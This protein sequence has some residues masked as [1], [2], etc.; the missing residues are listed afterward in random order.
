MR[1]RTVQSCIPMKPIINSK[2]S[3]G[4][5]SSL[6]FMLAVAMAATTQAAVTITNSTTFD[7]GTGLYRYSYSVTNTGTE[8]LILLTVPTVATAD[9]LGISAPSGFSLVYDP[10]VMIL[11]IREDNDI[12]TNNTFAAASTVAPFVFTSPLA[13]GLVTFTAFDVTGTEFTG[14]TFSPS[15]AAVPEPTASLLGAISLGLALTRR[16]RSA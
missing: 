1:H 14:T 6:G 8:D 10:F 7:A 11:D 3:L 2:R 16:R 12:F 9:L 15:V 13:P 5:L 4:A